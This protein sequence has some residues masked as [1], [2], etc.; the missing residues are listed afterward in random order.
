MYWT[1]NSGYIFVKT[2]GVF[3]QAAGSDFFYHIGGFGGYTTPTVNNLKTVTLNFPSGT[4]QFGSDHHKHLHTFVDVLK[5]VNGS[6]NISVPTT[7]VVMGG[8]T[9]PVIADNYKNMFKI[10]HVEAE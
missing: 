9:A 7:P 1:W 2:E 5:V 6:T 10:D 3:S 4:E 8:P